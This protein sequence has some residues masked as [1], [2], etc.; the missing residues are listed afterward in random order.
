MYKNTT[1][2]YVSLLCTDTIGNPTT[3]VAGSVT[4]AVT[5]D[6]G[7]PAYLTTNSGIPT[8]DS[9]TKAAGVYTCPLTQAE[10]NADKLNFTGASTNAGI[11]VV[12]WLNV[13]T[14]PGGFGDVTI[15]S[16]IIPANV[17]QTDGVTY[18]NY[19]GT[20]SA[21][22]INSSVSFPLTD[23]IGNTVPDA[24][25]FAWH[26]LEINGGTGSGQRVLLTTAGSGARQYNVLSGTFPNGADSTST[27]VM[28][29]NWRAN[30][31]HLNGTAQTARDIG[32]SVLLSVGTGTGQVNLSS[33][34]VP[35][36]LASTDVT[37]NVAADLQTIKTQTVTCSGGVTVP[38]ATLASTTNITAATGIDVTKWAGTTVATPDT[39]GYPKVTIK[40]GV[41][42]GEINLSS[43]KVPAT[44][45]ASD[46]TGNVASDVQTIKT[47]AVTCSAGVTV[48]VNVGTTQPLN[49]TGSAGSALVKT[50]MVD[51]AG[52]AVS[53]SSA[54]IGVNVINAAGTAWASG[55]VTSGVLAAS[56][57]TA[58]AGA[59]WDL[60]T[61]GHTNSGSFGA[62]MV[63]AGSA[64]DPWATSL[65]GSY[66]AG[67]A[68]HLIGTAIPDIA[69]G[70]AGGLLKAGSNASTT[71][72]ALIASIT[73]SLSGSV[74]SIAT[75]GIAAG[76]FAAGAVDATAFAQGAADKVWTT[77]SRTITDK[78]GFSL[79]STGADAVT[80]DGK[81]L[82]TALAITAALVGGKISGAGTGTETFI[83][84]NGTTTRAIVTVDTSGNRLAV[85]YP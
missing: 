82:P 79:S 22:T 30:T 81:T 62:A 60:G 80:V 19:D 54:Q 6:N 27:Y 52:S 41:G 84:I 9:S 55:A 23:A 49:F 21:A 34:K 4:F 12:P 40:S 75:G 68:G 36:T 24:G 16:G 31:T 74:G 46:V 47:Q 76:S 77:G 73:G 64:G 83:G 51:I 14:L 43:G 32:A 85:V 66:G 48:N 5:K 71:F 69:P 58:I 35:A 15:T 65:P 67:T 42:T 56:A 50:D 28:R 45:A 44:L 3:G 17:K 33:G 57:T 38:A 18:K 13:P 72:A 10:T 53:T 63:A 8:E 20:L 61:S 2:Q 29:A 26:E 78:L 37:G 11:V 39:A 59:V 7:S 1:G 70:A 25:Q